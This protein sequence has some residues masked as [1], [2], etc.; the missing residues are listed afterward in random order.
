MNTV[1]LPDGKR[2][3]VLG[4][5]TWTMGEKQ[6]AHK[7]EVAALRLGIDLGMTLIDTAEMY[8]DGA[9][10]KVVGDAI[11]GQRDRVFIVTKA[12]PHNASCSKLPKAC[13][14]SLKRLRIET[15]DLYLLHW[16]EKT[17]PLEETVETFEIL[18]AAGKIKRWGVSNFDVD[19]M[20]DLW[21]VKDGSICVTN[22]VLY[23]LENREME[24]DLLP[25]LTDHR[26]SFTCP[27]MAYSPV[28]HGRG[29]LENAALKK[30]AK[31]HEATTAQIAL[32]WVLRQPDVIAI[33]KAGD[34]NHVRDNARST[35]IKLTK[36]D[37]ADLDQKFPP[38][39]T[40]KPL[41]ML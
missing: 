5:G 34:K 31:H 9:A 12:Y 1:R 29:L 20:E 13:D 28:G 24:L 40:K 39:K 14:H 3:S 32:A 22:Q 11:E 35:E 41:P 27:I 33:P 4:Q 8:G 15:I 18:R 23:N 7:T 25:L 16:R 21:S 38:P 26:S 2:V 19:D 30:I 17:P 6:S 10:E 37:L 36:E